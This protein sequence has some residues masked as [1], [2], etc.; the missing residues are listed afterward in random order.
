MAQSKSKQTQYDE[1]DDDERSA[2]DEIVAIRDLVSDLE[3]RLRNL[4]SQVRSEASSATT[5]INRF[6]NEALSG[7]TDRVREGA[8]NVTQSVAEEASRSGT[9][10]IRRIGDEIETRP[11]ITLAIAAGI[12]FIL[13]IANRRS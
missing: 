8:H 12:G 13:G 5:D 9:D 1:K 3:D 4:N 11:F 10:V 6:V 2:Q 7:I